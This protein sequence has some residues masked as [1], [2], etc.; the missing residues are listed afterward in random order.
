M[1]TC[2]SADQHIKASI[3]P[4]VVQAKISINNKEKVLEVSPQKHEDSP[5]RNQSG[6]KK[7]IKN[8]SVQSE[9][10]VQAKLTTLN[11]GAVI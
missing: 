11:N 7:T 8:N 6:K 1:G 2:M 5:D 3:R 10:L 9:S 4:Q